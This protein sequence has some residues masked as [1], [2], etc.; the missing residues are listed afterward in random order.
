MLGVSFGNFENLKFQLL[1]SCKVEGAAEDPSWNHRGSAGAK[2]RRVTEIRTSKHR[3]NN[4]DGARHYQL[5]I[6]AISS[7]GELLTS[8]HSC[9][10]YSVLR[11]A[12]TGSHSDPLSD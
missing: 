3:K 7:Q 5:I 2:S 10:E 4:L 6:S 9:T 12:L 8:A 1:G 11:P